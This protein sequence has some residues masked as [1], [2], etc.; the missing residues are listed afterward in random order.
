MKQIVLA[1]TVASVVAGFA[2]DVWQV[3][4]NSDD[5]VWNENKFQ[6]G[7]GGRPGLKVRVG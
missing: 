6:G 1:L 2:D 3:P 7:L 4:T 5:F